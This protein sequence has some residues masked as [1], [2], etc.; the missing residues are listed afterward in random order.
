MFLQRK[1][2][3]GVRLPRATKPYVSVSR[4]IG[5]S[6]SVRRVFRHVFRP[7][8]LASGAR[9]PMPLRASL[10]RIRQYLFGNHAGRPSLSVARIGAGVTG[11]TNQFA[12][13]FCFIVGAIAFAV[14]W[15]RRE[16]IAHTAMGWVGLRVCGSDVSPPK[17]TP[18]AQVK[19]TSRK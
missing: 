15:R 7:S 16:L 6:A 2:G 12:R 14:I 9:F 19:R 11:L 3:K 1:L 8:R 13:L 18:L 4:L 5:Q 10:C 17:C